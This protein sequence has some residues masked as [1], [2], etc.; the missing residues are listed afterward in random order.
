[1]SETER[2]A[3]L[4]TAKLNIERKAGEG[5]NYT[6]EVESFYGNNYFYLL[7]YEK[8]NDVRLVGAPPTVNWQIWF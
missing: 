8:Y 5:N 2:S 6:A 4:I 7:I 1:M 3:V